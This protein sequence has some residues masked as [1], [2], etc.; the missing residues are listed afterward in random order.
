MDP[1]SELVKEIAELVAARVLEELHRTATVKPHLNYPAAPA[2]LLDVEGV[3]D[4]L[5]ISRRTVEKL[6][7]T[8]EIKPI[9][10]KGQRRFDRDAIEAYIRRCA[11]KRNTRRV[12]RG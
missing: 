12:K 11:E 8:G 9:R 7:S 6:I 1:N 3:A 5:G 10:V 4:W 2:P